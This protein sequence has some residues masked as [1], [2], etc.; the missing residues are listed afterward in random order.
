[1]IIGVKQVGQCITMEG[2]DVTE[3]QGVGELDAGKLLSLF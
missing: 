1:M 2:N 3:N